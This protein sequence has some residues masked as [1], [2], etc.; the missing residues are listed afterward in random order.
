M[1]LFPGNDIRHNGTHYRDVEDKSDQWFGASLQSSL[2]GIIVVSPFH[3]I[4]KTCPCNI[5][6]VD[7]S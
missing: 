4:I 6:N 5:Y 3:L 1:S 2:N 7:F